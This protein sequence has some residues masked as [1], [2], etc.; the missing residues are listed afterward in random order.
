[1]SRFLWA[2]TLIAVVSIGY[3]V[4]TVAAPLKSMRCQRVLGW[5]G[6]W[7]PGANTPIGMDLKYDEDDPVYEFAY[8]GDKE[9]HRK[10]IWEGN[11]DPYLNGTKNDYIE[12]TL[13]GRYENVI[14]AILY[15][16]GV[17]ATLYQIDFDNLRVLSSD[18]GSLLQVGSAMALSCEP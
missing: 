12:M 16:G 5:S 18:V 8:D 15:R 7:K 17:G 6:G 1:M 9:V 13:V 2:L 14:L 11:S 3:S 4:E 10:M